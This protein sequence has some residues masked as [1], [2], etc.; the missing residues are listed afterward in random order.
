MK[1][2][3]GSILKSLCWLGMQTSS[4]LQEAALIQEAGDLMGQMLK[5]MEEQLKHN[6]AIKQS[7]EMDWSDKKETYEI[8]AINVGLRITS[9][10]LLFKPGATRFPDGSVGL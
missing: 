8:E 3:K 2:C 9:K 6:K 1:N 4:L 7:L 5:Q 10:T